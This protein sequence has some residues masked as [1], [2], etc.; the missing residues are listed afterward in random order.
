[1][2][3]LDNSEAL[4][5]TQSFFLRRF[6]MLMWP[7]QLTLCAGYGFTVPAVAIA[8]Q[9][10]HPTIDL[11]NTPLLARV[12]PM[13]TPRFSSNLG[14]RKKLSVGTTKCCWS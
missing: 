3:S 8:C 2:A 1:M 6:Q 5:C 4:T 11:M 14:F 13:P 7:E 12:T 9:N 10:A